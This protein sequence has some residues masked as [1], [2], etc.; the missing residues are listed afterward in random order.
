[1]AQTAGDIHVPC[2]WVN[3]TAGSEPIVAAKRGYLA[4]SAGLSGDI[5]VDWQR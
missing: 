5:D 4:L 2:T 3:W 1:M